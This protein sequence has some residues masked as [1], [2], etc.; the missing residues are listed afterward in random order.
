MP[1]SKTSVRRLRAQI[2]R[3][4]LFDTALSLFFERGYDNV[5][6]DDVCAAVG[7]T[8]GA[9]YSHFKSKHDIL[10]ERVLILDDYYK[11]QILPQLAAIDPGVE[12]VVSFVRLMLRHLKGLG[13]DAIR[14]VYYTQI[15]S[16]EITSVMT[17]K[18]ILYKIIQH[19][20]EEA[21][22]SG[23]LRD[24]LSSNELTQIIM[25]NIRGILYNWGLSTSKFDIEESAEGLIKVLATGLQKQKR[26]TGT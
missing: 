1:K 13:K 22:N 7:M 10:V 17:E 4:K 9:F 15:G 11:L 21:Q 20:V 19:L 5:T 14:A 6:V 3:Q 26:K 16:K 25:H 24:D 2:T 23:K 18:R 12:K 8:K